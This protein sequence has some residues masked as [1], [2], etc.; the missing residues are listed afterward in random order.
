MGPG[1]GWV[2]LLAKGC[3]YESG[4]EQVGSG[5][6]RK[7]RPRCV[8]FPAAPHRCHFRQRRGRG[9]EEGFSLLSVL[10]IEAQG[11]HGSQWSHSSRA[12]SLF[13]FCKV[14]GGKWS[15]EGWVI[16]FFFCTP[17]PFSS[18]A[19][20]EDRPPCL[21]QRAAMPQPRPCCS[22]GFVN[23]VLGNGLTTESLGA[24]SP[25]Q[26]LLCHPHGAGF[27]SSTKQVGGPPA[28][29]SQERQ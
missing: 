4:H 24:V 27:V 26:M 23:G 16:F 11:S 2:L 29:Q 7:S 1:E 8:I 17:F 22:W 21:L 14:K 9:V 15:G 18:E 19:R 5:R 25:L 12:F 28:C 20:P 10:Q 3:C 6:G 13:F